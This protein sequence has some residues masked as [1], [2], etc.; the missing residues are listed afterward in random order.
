ME[1]NLFTRKFR[2][3]T[4][5]TFITV[6]FIGLSGLITN[7]LVQRELGNEILGVY[8]Y[9][10]SAFLIV[11][12]IASFGLNRSLV[13]FCSLH[14]DDKS[15]LSSFINSGLALGIG[16][17]VLVSICIRFLLYFF[18]D[19]IEANLLC[20]I[21]VLLWCIPLYVVNNI[22]IAVCNGLGEMKAY[23]LLRSV[24][25]GLLLVAQYFS[26]KLFTVELL[27]MGYIFSELVL[28]ILT[29]GVL[30]RLKIMSKIWSSL[31]IRELIGYGK[32]M[33]PSQL[34]LSI[35]ENSDIIL[36]KL[37][38]SESYLGVYS[39]ASRFSKLLFL[40]GAA[41]QSNVNPIISRLYSKGNLKE[42]TDFFRLLKIKLFYLY[43]IF[44]PALALFY[45]GFIDFYLKDADF[46]HYYPGFLIS[47]LGVSFIG[48]YSWSGGVL[49]M[50][51]NPLPNLYRL[52]FRLLTFSLIMVGC[53][54]YQENSL[55]PYVGYSAGLLFN[56]VIDKY[57]IQ[58]FTNIRIY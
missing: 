14:R 45:W 20:H 33:Y 55:F 3:N 41:V 34:V 35:Q 11:T 21:H 10:I 13:Y 32:Y 2:A 36:L 22:C 46:Y 30:I 9:V 44:Y 50:T 26:I 24:R 39:L 25:W 8:N 27:F 6:A 52:L 16:L 29:I 49:L 1:L 19:L 4:T 57:F 43:C 47:L 5:L 58:K 53:S 31:A 12:S 42:L 51:G 23:S 28:L 38:V 48:L 37:F 15:N 54:A 40:M 56:L 7:Y 18:G 17:S